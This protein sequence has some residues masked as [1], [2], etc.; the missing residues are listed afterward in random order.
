MADSVFQY[1]MNIEYAEYVLEKMIHKSKKLT[2]IS[3]IHDIDLKD[4][5]LE[6]R[7]SSMENYDQIYQGLDKMFYSRKWFVDIANKNHRNVIFT[8][9]VNAEYWNSKYI[10]NCFIY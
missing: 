1:F 4:E 5:W 6:Y 3:E 2:Y 9:S 8:Q 7:R 10:F